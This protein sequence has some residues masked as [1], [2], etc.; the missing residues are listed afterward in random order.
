[1][2]KSLMIF[3]LIGTTG[4]AYHQSLHGE[5]VYDDTGI[6]VKNPLVRRP[7]PLS[8]YFAT[9][10][11]G[12]AGGLYRPLTILSYAINHR[13]TGLRSKAFHGVNFLLH[14]AVTALLAWW[15]LQM[16]FPSFVAALAAFLF[17]LLPVHTE[18]V[19]SIVGRAELLS[20]LF[21]LIAWML[22]LKKPTPLRLAL[23]SLAFGAALLSKENAAALVPALI[24]GDYSLTK[25]P[26]REF[27]RERAL[28]WI[29]AAGTLGLYLEWRTIIMG[30]LTGVGG[31]P[32]FSDQSWIIRL[33]T[34]SSFF[35]AHYAR[36]MV[37]GGPFSADFTRPQLSDAVLTDPRVWIAAAA[38]V[39]LIGAA[40]YSFWRKKSPLALGT[41]VFFI[42][43]VPVANLFVQL[44][45]IGAERFLY[46]PSIG[47]ALAAALLLSRLYTWNKQGGIAACVALGLFYATQTYARDGIW[48]NEKTF[49]SAAVLDAPNSPRSWNGLGVVEMSEKKYAEAIG[50]FKK[51]IEL[52]VRLLDAHYNLA[53][54]TLLSGDP[55][56]ARA[57]FLY[58]LEERPEDMNALYQLA[59]LAEKEGKSQAALGYYAKMHDIDPHDM[60]IQQKVARLRG[61]KR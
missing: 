9:A 49:W 57:G 8:R 39:A 3:L 6:I 32:Y 11:W 23:G 7:A 54:S 40:A 20:A 34:M 47:Y 44:E 55:V 52:N 41:L 2:K 29:C 15:L 12:S 51:A 58:V 4:L 37:F 59:A 19:S 43:L 28:V 27:A 61:I 24:A 22:Y 18:A 33:L 31:F 36:P 13:I 48:R 50:H 46:L 30:S 60:W 38:L 25:K 21:V 16:G 10:Y 45:I 35:W 26:L 1:M 5:F 42:F 17:A 14:L 53:L 56:K